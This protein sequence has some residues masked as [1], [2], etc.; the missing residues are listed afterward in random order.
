MVALGEDSMKL[1]DGLG[2]NPR[3]VRMFIA[4]KKLDVETEFVDL[5]AGA[6]R[7]E[8][9]TR[10]NP[11]GQLPSLQ[12]DDGRVIAE[13]TVICEY[14]EERQPE[15]ALIGRT[16]EER[17]EARMWLRRVELHV[18]EPLAN[19][20]R[21]GEGRKLF[22]GRIRLIP[23]ASDDLKALAREGLAKL[24]ALIAGRP[25]VAGERLTLGDLVLFSFLDFGAS[26]GQKLDPANRNLAAWFER[27][28]ARPSAAASAQPGSR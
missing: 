23:H 28:A 25:F 12:L 27:M 20:F 5:L 19:G 4:E 14:L 18:T 7:R 17:A 1:Y 13:T 6:N 9:Y 8:P 11:F 16:A 2:P 26:V 10:A 24:D 21:Y 22:E 15:P 3:L